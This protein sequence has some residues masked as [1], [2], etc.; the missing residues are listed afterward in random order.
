VTARAHAGTLRGTRG[1]R[2]EDETVIKL[3]C[4]TLIM[5]ALVACDDDTVTDQGNGNPTD[6]YEGG[7]VTNDLPFSQSPDGPTLTEIKLE[8]QSTS[9]VVLATVT[10]P[11]GTPNLLGIIQTIGM[12]PDKD[13]AETALELEDD[14]AGSGL[15]E[16]FGDVVLVSENQVLYDKI[17]ACES[18]PVEVTFKDGDGNVTAGRVVATVID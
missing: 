13:C 9:I 8:C 5:L 11:Q 15:E 3:L 18:W 16:S 7:C 4:T 17:C 10:D 1:F 14:L 2:G 12:F 6:C